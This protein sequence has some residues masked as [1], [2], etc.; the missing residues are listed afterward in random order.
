[1]N[2]SNRRKATSDRLTNIRAYL[3]KKNKPELVALLLDLVQETDEPTR[4]RF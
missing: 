2:M 3:E 4:Q 1:M